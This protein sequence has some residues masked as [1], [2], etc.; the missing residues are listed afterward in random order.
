MT[1]ITADATTLMRQATANEYLRQGVED[2]DAM[3]GRAHRRGRRG[4]GGPD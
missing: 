1:G 2:I 4:G 3:F